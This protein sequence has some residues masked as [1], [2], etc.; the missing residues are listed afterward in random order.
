MQLHTIHPS[1]TTTEL[2]NES[3]SPLT[4]NKKNQK[5]SNEDQN[6]NGSDSAVL[7]LKSRLE[8]MK[9]ERNS[10]KESDTKFRQIR[11]HLVMKIHQFD[12]KFGDLES[13]LRM[14]P[15][16]LVLRFVWRRSPIET[17]LNTSCSEMVILDTIL[18]YS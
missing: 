10:F 13:L 6:N 8:K 2:L 9:K 3:L 12:S 5:D 4:C 17:R 1:S 14:E 11:D 7:T 18:E 16:K 15:S